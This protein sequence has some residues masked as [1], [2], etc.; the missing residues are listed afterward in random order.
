MNTPYT[1]LRSRG[2]P[3]E[4]YETSSHFAQ[5]L[6][7]LIDKCVYLYLNTA[8]E[9]YGSIQT[10]ASSDNTSQGKQYF[11]KL[12]YLGRFSTVAKAKYTFLSIVIVMIKLVFTTFTLEIFSQWRI[13]SR[14]NFV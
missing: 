11:N 13:L 9:R 14:E 4:H 10:P 12:P 6:F 1:I 7:H 5:E 2:L 3:Q 8:I